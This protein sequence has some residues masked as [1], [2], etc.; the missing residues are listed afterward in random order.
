MYMF[1]DIKHYIFHTCSRIIAT[2]FEFCK[3]REEKAPRM[4]A[5][6]FLDEHI[7]TGYFDGVERDGFCGVGMLLLVKRN[8]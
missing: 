3:E 1:Q 7:P 8:N 4:L 2:F 5:M 6:P